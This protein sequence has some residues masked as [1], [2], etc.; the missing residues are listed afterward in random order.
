MISVASISRSSLVGMVAVSWLSILLLGGAWIGKMYF[1]FSVESGQLRSEHYAAQRALVKEEVEKG[2]ALVDD[3]R[4]SRLRELWHTIRAI[5]AQAQAQATVLTGIKPAMTPGRTRQSVVDVLAAG[6]ADAPGFF[7]VH[8]E[9]LFLLQPFPQSIDRESAMEQLVSAL[10][11][12]GQ[13]ERHVSIS[14]PGGRE[15]FTLLLLVEQLPALSMRI[16]S[17]ACLEVAEAGFMDYAVKQLEARRFGD[18]SS[19]FGGTWDGVSVMGPGKGKSMWE[20]ADVNGV[21]IVQELVATS[22]R[23][24]GFVSYVMPKIDGHR[25]TDKVSFA[26]PI[27]DWQW[28]IGA[29]VYV[30]DIESV[31]TANKEK[32]GREIAYQSGLI[33]AGLALLSSVAF[34]LSR[35]FSRKVQEHTLSFTE[36]WNRASTEGGLVDPDNLRYQEFKELAAAANRMLERRRAAE[37]LVSESAARFHTLVS[38][39]PGIVYHCIAAKPWTM[40][41]I[42]DSVEDITGYPASDFINDAVRSFYSIIDP[43]DVAWVTQ[44][45]HDDIKSHRP[46]SLEYRII[47]QNGDIRWVFERG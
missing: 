31:I 26:M 19:F 17:G 22:R 20:V 27:S 5:A 30:D 29:G 40:H 8:G 2:V 45:I 13:G 41:F 39:I 32:L 28:Y 16:V 9:T 15:H 36:V 38:N 44:T 23:G 42:S 12:V 43:R 35:R 10:D 46:F 47:R 3:I 34:G 1:D 21:K 11:G 24:G 4:R 6:M 25:H 37:A 33:L 18:G 14:S 7:S